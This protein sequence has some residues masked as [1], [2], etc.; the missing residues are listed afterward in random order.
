M[1][2]QQYYESNPKQQI[3]RPEMKGLFLPFTD[4]LTL[5]FKVLIDFDDNKGLFASEEHVNSALAYLKRIGEDVRYELLKNFISNF[6]ALISDYE[7][8]ILSVEGLDIIYNAKAWEAFSTSDDEMDTLVL[9][10]RETIDMRIQSLIST[11][12]HIWYDN[13]RSVEVLPVNLRRFNLSIFLFSAGYYS[14]LLYDNLD[15]QLEAESEIKRFILPTSN[16]LSKLVNKSQN[17][18]FNNLLFRLYGCEIHQDSGKNFVSDISNEMNSEFV[19][20]NLNITYKTANY[21][22]VFNSDGKYI[23]Q[24]FEMLGNLSAY[25]KLHNLSSNVKDSSLKGQ[26]RDLKTKFKERKD[27]W[28]NA[29]LKTR[30]KDKTKSYTEAR[31]KSQLQKVFAENTPIGE[32]L[33]ALNPEFVEKSA[34]QIFNKGFTIF[35]DK[36]LNDPLSRLNNIISSNFNIHSLTNSGKSTKPLNDKFSITVNPKQQKHLEYK[37]YENIYNKVR[38]F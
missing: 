31:L 16:K 8:L 12:R 1:E 18:S 7:F 19:R 9:T 5:N 27:A 17:K 30:L 3:I 22:G 37:E 4:P 6:K 15:N 32:V 25:N 20:N 10:I 21:L 23:S 33:N 26:L 2:K 24:L 34:M 11:Y 14:N 29:D 38:K 36:L 28:K 13:I 35:E